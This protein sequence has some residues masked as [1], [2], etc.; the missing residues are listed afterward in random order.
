VWCVLQAEKAEAA[1]QAAA[2]R[3]AAAEQEEE[4]GEADEEEEE[5]EDEEGSAVGAGD[6][7]PDISAIPPVAEADEQEA[8]DEVCAL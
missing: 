7:P 8:D 2:A 4:T 3:A 5:E 6:V 1:A